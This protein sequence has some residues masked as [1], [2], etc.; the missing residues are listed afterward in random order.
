LKFKIR[1]NI[2]ID[3]MF[4]PFLLKKV[5][6]PALLLYGFY[7]IYLT[8]VSIVDT[9]RKSEEM[10]NKILGLKDEKKNLEDKFQ[11]INS[12]DFVEK[13]ARTKLNM[14]KEGEDVYILP[15]NEAPKSQEISYVEGNSSNLNKTSN[16]QKWMELLF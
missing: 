16:F 8:T 7:N 1:G 13:E 14:K 6:L 5:V 3:T 9:A 2:L 10:H 12:D 11:I 4:L 15:S